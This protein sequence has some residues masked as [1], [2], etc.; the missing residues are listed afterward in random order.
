MRNSKTAPASATVKAGNLPVTPENVGQTSTLQ[1]AMLAF[2]IM[3]AESDISCFDGPAGTGK[4]TASSLAASQ[5]NRTWRYCTLPLRGNPRDITATVFEAVTGRAAR[6]TEREMRAALVDRLRDGTIGI[7][8][9]EVHHVGLPGAQQ[10]RHLWDACAVLG[11]PFPLLLIGCG[12]RVELARADEV[13]TRVA[14][15]VDFDLITDDEDVVALAGALHPR[16][17]A[18]SEKI[19]VG[20]NE[21]V[22]RRS[23]R[24]WSQIGKHIAYLPTTVV[25]AKKPEPITAADV[26]TLRDLLGIEGIAA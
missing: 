8:A 9:D 7:I 15:W 2:R 4:T 3:D 18:T 11:E 5:S 14:R 20:I 21:R 26:H 24:T 1:R 17:A 16:L 25:G 10:L 6:G 12:V 19:L 22:A 13:R 23:V